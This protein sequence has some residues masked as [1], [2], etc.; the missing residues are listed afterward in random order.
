MMNF[1]TNEIIICLLMYVLLFYHDFTLLFSIFVRYTAIEARGTVDGYL[2]LADFRWLNRLVTL[3][4]LLPIGSIYLAF[5]FVR[6]EIAFKFFFFFTLLQ[7]LYEFYFLIYKFNDPF[8]TLVHAHRVHY[9][10]ILWKYY[11]LLNYFK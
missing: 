10:F 9:I 2:D 7:F 5:L 4:W 11:S 1:G 8:P 6:G 3:V